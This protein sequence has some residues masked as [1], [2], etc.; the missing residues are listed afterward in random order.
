MQNVPYIMDDYLWSR[1]INIKNC[2]N[3]LKHLPEPV[4]AVF[5]NVKNRRFVVYGHITMKTPVIVRKP[6]LSP[7]S[8]RMGDRLGISDAVDFGH[9][10]SIFII[11]IFII[12]I[13]SCFFVLFFFSFFLFDNILFLLFL[14]K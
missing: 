3:S 2:P 4:D 10:F 12:I 1:A 9:L 13:I 11:Y 5:I 8:T 14:Y 7:V 6:K